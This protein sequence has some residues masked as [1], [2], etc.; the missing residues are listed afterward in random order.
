M[1]YRSKET[2]DQPEPYTSM[3][4]LITGNLQKSL[5]QISAEFIKK[6]FDHA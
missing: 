1:V 3:G 4:C 6:S 5:Q 2:D